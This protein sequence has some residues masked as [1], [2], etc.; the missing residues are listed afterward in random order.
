LERE[1]E[2]L[3]RRLEELAREHDASGLGRGDLSSRMKSAE[4]ERDAAFAEQTRL[5]RLVKELE[6]ERSVLL[7]Q[8]KVQQLALDEVRDATGKQ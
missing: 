7:E 1:V 8:A 4:E 2:E 3:R 6:I 5:S